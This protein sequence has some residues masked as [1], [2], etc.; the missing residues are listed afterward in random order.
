M[1]ATPKPAG[2]CKPIIPPITPIKRIVMH[3]VRHGIHD[4][5]PD[6]GGRTLRAGRRVLVLQVTSRRRDKEK[7][8]LK[9]SYPSRSSR[10]ALSAAKRSFSTTVPRSRWS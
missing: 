5:A 8:G 9:F 6:R 4:F 10:V 3:G 1:A 2:I 7:T